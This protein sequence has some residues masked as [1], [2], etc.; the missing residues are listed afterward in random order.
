MNL[1]DIPT[2][3]RRRL[4]LRAEA[5][6]FLLRLVAHALDRAHPGAQREAEILYA[7]RQECGFV[8]EHLIESLSRPDWP[9][10]LYHMACDQ[11]FLVNT[12]QT[13]DAETVR[14]LAD[15]WEAWA[16]QVDP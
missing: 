10:G 14:G 5:A 15:A 4:A 12:N 7:T 8:L 6:A 3:T 2:A 1:A 13:L 9:L 11:R 16:G